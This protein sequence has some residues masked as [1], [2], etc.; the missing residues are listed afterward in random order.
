MC[1]YILYTHILNPQTPQANKFVVPRAF[2]GVARGPGE[3]EG[4]EAQGAEGPPS[5]NSWLRVWGLGIGVWGLGFRVWGLGLRLG[6]SGVGF[7]CLF[8]TAD[9]FV[10]VEGSALR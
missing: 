8:G 9:S 2:P 7:R 1:K 3:A 10:L 4:E 6:V 5:W